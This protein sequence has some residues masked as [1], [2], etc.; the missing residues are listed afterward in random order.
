MVVKARKVADE[1]AKAP[2]SLGSGWVEGAG[3]MNC[4]GGV[5]VCVCVLA[6]KVELV[7]MKCM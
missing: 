2:S 6:G 3:G 1:E 5:C 7:C 4:V